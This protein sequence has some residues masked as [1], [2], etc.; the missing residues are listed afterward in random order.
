MEP[1]GLVHRR[2]RLPTEIR[3]GKV[4][5]TQLNIGIDGLALVVGKHG[6]AKE[7]GM[8]AAIARG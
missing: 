2:A 8:G 5:V 3:W 6:Q 4:R 7:N 1:R